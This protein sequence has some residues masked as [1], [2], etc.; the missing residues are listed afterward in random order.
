MPKPVL[1]H[2][3]G[4]PIKAIDNYGTE[5]WEWSL[6]LENGVVIRNYDKRRTATPDVSLLGKPLETVMLSELE[7]RIRIDKDNEIVLT[8]TKYSI[9]DPASSVE[10][11]EVFPQVPEELDDS[12]PPDPSEER[13]QQS[14]MATNGQESDQER[15]GDQEEV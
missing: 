15:D 9:S 2:Y 3:V 1:D 4:Y 7:T 14:S 12:L 6:V 5:E 8:P 13:T 10:Y 11:G